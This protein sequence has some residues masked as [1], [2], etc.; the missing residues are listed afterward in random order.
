MAKADKFGGGLG[1]KPF[2]RRATD[3]RR[4]GTET[5]ERGTAAT[6]RLRFVLPTLRED[7]YS[8]RVNAFTVAANALRPLNR[9]EQTQT[10]AA[11]AE[12]FQLS[13]TVENNT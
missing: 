13:L 8:A 6:N 7:Q 10:I 9:V 5:V 3:I 1:K 11:L 12:F 4:G 2:T